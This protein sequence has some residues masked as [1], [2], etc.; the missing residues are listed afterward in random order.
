MI[1]Q[2]IGNKFFN[3]WY[4]NSIIINSLINIDIQQIQAWIKIIIAQV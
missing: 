4:F 3:E 1:F 2:F